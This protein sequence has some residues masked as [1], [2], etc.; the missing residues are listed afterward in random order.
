MIWG[1]SLMIASWTWSPHTRKPNR[2]SVHHR[3]LTTS[4]CSSFRQTPTSCKTCVHRWQHQVA[5]FI[6][7][8]LLPSKWSRDVSSMTSHEPGFKSDRACLGHTR[9]SCTGS[10]T[11]CTKLTS[12]GS[13]IA[14][15]MAAATTAAHL[16]TDCREETDDKGRH[17]STWWFHSILDF[18]SVSVSKI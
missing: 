8:N 6:G 10:W 4:C 5:S 15:G 7:S 16:T 3:C 1:V 2:W 11:S 12:I 9:P 14:S 18:E 17:P 13:N